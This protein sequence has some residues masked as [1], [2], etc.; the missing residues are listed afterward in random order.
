MNKWW[1]EAKS[2][3][4]VKIPRPVSKLCDSEDTT[5]HV[6]CDASSKAY[7]A[8]VY[9][10]HGGESRLVIAKAR[11]APLRPGIT[12]PRLELMAALIGVR[13]MRFVKE[14]LSIHTSSAQYWTD[15]MDVLYW[16]QSKKPLKVFVKNRV[17]SILE[18]SK[19]EQWKYVETSLNP[20]DLGTR[21]IPLRGLVVSEQWW[22]GPSFL[23]LE[24]AMNTA[25]VQPTETQ[26]SEAAKKEIKQSPTSVRCQTAVT[27]REE[28]DSSPVDAAGPFRLTDCSTLKSAVNKTAW[29]RRFIHNASH[30][31]QDRIRGPLRPEER[32]S[33]LRLWIKLA[34]RSAYHSELQDI[35]GGRAVSHHSPLSN[36]RPH[37]DEEGVLRATPRTGEPAMIILPDLRHITTLIIDHAHR[38][39]FHQGVRS[40]LALLSS[41]YLVRRIAVRR[42]VQTCTRCRRYRALPF[43]QPEGPLP[44]FRIQASRSFESVGIDYF[45]PLYISEGSK[46]WGLLITCATTRAIHLEVVRSQSTEDLQSAL[47][48]FFALRGTPSLIMS[49]NAKSF[50]KILGLLPSSVKWRFIPESSPWW[51]GFWERLVGS[52]K[53]SMKIT[54]HQCHLAHDELV[55]VFYEL[56]M[57]LNLRPLTGDVVDGLLT[58]AHF[59]FGV[60]H[61]QGVVNPAVD[62]TATL[63]RA[64]RNRKRVA[65]HLV[66]RWKK[67]YL[68]TLRAWS[69]SSRGRPVRTPHA[70]EIVMVQGE[71]SRGRW[72]LGRVQSLIHG[73]DGKPRAA[74]VTLRGRRTRRPV[75]KLYRLEASSDDE[76]HETATTPEPPSDPCPVTQTHVSDTESS[77]VASHQHQTTRSG[78]PV[79]PTYRYGS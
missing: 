52:V 31:K 17:S 28:V 30:T 42:V 14:T 20:A 8:V 53:A 7:C 40:T 75:S 38:L 47:R 73:R 4:E 34:Q 76:L 67:E 44:E 11:L 63:T 74:V 21:G 9:A 23:T 48:R 60:T 78:R 46:V 57:H 37:L 64:W 54:L 27:V 41:E 51:G 35:R 45:G 16:L 1:E 62:P 12:I 68:Q 50:H 55:T 13:L 33:A 25:D 6:F 26:V 5:F 18:D 70:G 36:F 71:G 43:R 58:P 61:I 72:P 69:T 29:I 65:E 39:C 2:I 19:P 66:Q 10:V 56:A 15:S 3:Q 49:D 59:I 79:R 22:T 32:Q 77:Q 24:E